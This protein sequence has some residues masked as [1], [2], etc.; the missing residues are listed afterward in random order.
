MAGDD[1]N[2]PN[3]FSDWWYSRG[4]KAQAEK[5]QSNWDRFWRGVAPRYWEPF[6]I[7]NYGGPGQPYNNPRNPMGVPG[8]G[9]YIG[10]GGGGANTLYRP[11][12]PSTHIWPSMGTPYYTS[13]G[14]TPPGTGSW[15]D[16]RGPWGRGWDPNYNEMMGVY[17]NGQGTY[18][19][20]RANPDYNPADPNSAAYVFT[21]TGTER[22]QWGGAAG[23]YGRGQLGYAYR[24]NRGPSQ[25]NVGFRAY[26]ADVDPEPGQT[27][28]RYSMSE[29]QNPWKAY[30]A[31][32]KRRYLDKYGIKPAQGS[33]VTSMG[34]GGMASWNP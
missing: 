10:A 30:A 33:G 15:D 14:Y 17:Q 13:P 9:R 18:G 12:G 31:Y 16:L 21:S 24:P 3:D 34:V 5:S 11:Y 32:R 20:W 29:N 19:G 22:N 25:S 23:S 1:R 27:S 2:N 4:R 8:G 6:S 28:G 26:Q 7:F